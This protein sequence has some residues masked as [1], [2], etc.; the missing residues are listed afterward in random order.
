MPS[1]RHQNPLTKEQKAKHAQHNRE[2]HAQKTIENDQTLIHDQE[3]LLTNM[4]SMRHHIPIH[5]KR[6]LAKPNKSNSLK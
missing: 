1:P 2:Y 5:S 6:Q 3:S 4:D